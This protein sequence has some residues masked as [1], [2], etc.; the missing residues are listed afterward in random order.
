MTI[1]IMQ[2]AVFITIAWLLHGSAP[3]PILGGAEQ[4][5]KS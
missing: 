1:I 2:M 4:T 5:E 3:E